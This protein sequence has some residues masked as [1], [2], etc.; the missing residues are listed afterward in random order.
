MGKKIDIQQYRYEI[1][2]IVF[3]FE[4][5]DEMNEGND[6]IVSR[7]PFCSHS[8]PRSK[9]FDCWFP[10]KPGTLAPSDHHIAMLY[11]NTSLFDPSSLFA[12]VI[13]RISC[14]EYQYYSVSVM[15]PREYPGGGCV[16]L[17]ARDNILLV[18]LRISQHRSGS[19]PVT[20]YQKERAITSHLDS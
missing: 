11:P 5:M 20:F 7:T 8:D 1:C 14:C 10:Y 13:Y 18:N 3:V 2:S 4:R 9:L 6:N 17:V 15:L 16:A 19:Q 12:L